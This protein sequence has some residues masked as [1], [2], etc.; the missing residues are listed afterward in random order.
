[1]SQEKIIARIENGSQNEIR[2]RQSEYK[3]KT[4]IDV[5]KWY[6]SPPDDSTVMQDVERPAEF[7]RPTQKG[8]SLSPEQWTE[9][10]PV[11]IELLGGAEQS[12]RKAA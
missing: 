6:F 8:I 12:A 11:I 10:A 5:R 2:V 1:M 9:I 4:Y 3:G 7:F